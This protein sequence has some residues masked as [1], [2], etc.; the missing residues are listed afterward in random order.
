MNHPVFIIMGVSG[1]G[2]TTLAQALAEQ[3]GAAFIEGDDLHSPEA[4]AKIAAGIAL[5]DAD[6]WPWLDRIADAANAARADGPVIATCSAL[7]RAYRDRLRASIAAP[8]RFIFLDVAE[9]ELAQRLRARGGHYMGPEMLASQL[10]I[11]EPP[12]N[13]SDVEWRT[14]RPRS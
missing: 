9:D 12:L 14:P 5:T 13:E 11:L 1:A 4:R 2:K 3:N 7:R 8:F 10:A 6:R